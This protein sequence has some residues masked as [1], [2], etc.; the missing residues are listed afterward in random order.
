MTS[1]LGY[2]PELIPLTLSAGS[3]FTQVLEAP[4]G[5]TF[6]SGTTSWIVLHSGTTLLDT[7]YGVVDTSTVTWTIPAA[8][9][10]PIPAGARYRIYIQD[11]GA[12]DPQEWMYGPIERAE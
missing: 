7:W 3:L 6:A 12:T 4:T 8:K 11:P 1:A 2:Q 5:T 10:D 9:T